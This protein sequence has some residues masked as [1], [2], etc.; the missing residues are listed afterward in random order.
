MNVA[1][2]SHLAAVGMLAA[3]AVGCR[4]PYY[5]DQGALL[6]GLAGAGVGAAIGEHNDNPLA[7]AAIGAVVG[8]LTGAAI[9]DNIDHDVARNNAIIEQRMGQRLAGAVSI[10]QVVSM[11]RA[12]LSDDV[13]ITHIQANGVAQRPQTGDLIAL[14]EQGVSDR[15]INAMQSQAPIA[16]ATPLPPPRPTPVIVEEYYYGHPYY[17]P[18]PPCY[19]RPPYYG[20]HWGFSYSSRH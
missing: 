10:P 8:T 7:G 19:R 20:S 1:R 14:K 13:I 11:T 2:F 4:S 5:A 16:Y 9:G 12:G 17:Y 15:V 6:G 18:P 3:A